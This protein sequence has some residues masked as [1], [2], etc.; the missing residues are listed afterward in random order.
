MNTTGIGDAKYDTLMTIPCGLL[1]AIVV[2]PD[3]TPARHWLPALLD[4]RPLVAIGLVSYSLFLWH[5]PLT[6]WLREQGLTR[7]GTGG[8]VV[9]LVA[10]PND[11]EA[12]ALAGETLTKA[13]G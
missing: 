1:L 10:T 4:S 13:L 3:P 11:T 9:N 8:F 5:E 7:A 2:L 12:I 6:H